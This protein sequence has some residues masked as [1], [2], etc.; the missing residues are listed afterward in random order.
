[1]II[2]TGIYLSKVN[3]GNTRTMF[4]ICPKSTIK[5]AERPL[6]CFH[7]CLG[8]GKRQLALAGLDCYLKVL[9]G[10]IDFDFLIVKS[11][12][13][14]LR[15]NFLQDILENTDIR[16]DTLFI[17]SLVHDV[18]K[19]CR[20]RWIEVK[21]DNNSTESKFGVNMRNMFKEFNI[22][23]FRPFHICTLLA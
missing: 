16:L 22:I 20:N 12:S 13:K 8:K 14:N 10:N 2:P 6:W 18:I 19:V 23:Y 1:M 7:C 11:G 17:L 5:I 15:N 3:N 21:V 9:P 4:K